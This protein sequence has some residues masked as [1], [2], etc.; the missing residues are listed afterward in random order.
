MDEL[1]VVQSAKEGEEPSGVMVIQKIIQ[2]PVGE[3]SKEIKANTERLMAQLKERA[4]GR[5]LE[6]FSA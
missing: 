1:E 4:G 2:S 3:V 6:G 5:R